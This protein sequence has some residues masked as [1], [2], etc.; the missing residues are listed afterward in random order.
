M[1]LFQH[2]IYWSSTDTL[3]A[4]RSAQ[5]LVLRYLP[6]YAEYEIGGSTI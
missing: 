4:L 6:N 2:P 3:V 5:M 1:L